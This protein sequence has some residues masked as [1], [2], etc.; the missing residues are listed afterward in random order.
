MT[1]KEA[2]AL[3]LKRVNYKRVSE[4]LENGMIVE[5]YSRFDK[6]SN[7]KYDVKVMFTVDEAYIFSYED[8]TGGR[9]NY[10]SVKEFISHLLS[11]H[12]NLPHS[13]PIPYEIETDNG[14][15]KFSGSLDIRKN[16]G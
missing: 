3:T 16:E 14:S 11:V 12:E 4:K 5:Y 13:E 1:I 10:T 2:S 9:C 15:T 6:S 8:S 7:I